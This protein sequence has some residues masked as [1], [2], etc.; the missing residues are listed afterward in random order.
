MLGLA[1]AAF[2][3]CAATEFASPGGPEPAGV[4]TVMGRLRQDPYD[5]E[6]LISFG[7]SKGGSAGHLALALREPGEPD[8]WV[9]SANFYADRAA[10]HAT[11]FYTDEL[12]VRVPKNEYLYGT[13]SSL[14]PAAQ[15]GLDYGEVYKRT[16]VGVR[17][18]GVPRAER[19]ALAAFFARINAD[20]R[21]RAA[22]TAYHQG[23]VV[24]DYM[25]FNCAKSIGAAFR[26]GAG[27][28][29]LEVKEPKVLP[30]V[31]R[32]VRATQAN[33][34]SDMALK[35]M[36]E[37]HA[38]GRTM[39]VVLYKKYPGSGWI[40]PLEGEPKVA[41]RELPNRFPSM[42]SLDFAN[43]QGAYEDYDNL[44]AMYLLYN[45]GKYSVVV[46]PQTW[47]LEIE[48]SKTPMPYARAEYFAKSAARADSRGF[49]RR[50]P[51]IPKGL[52]IGDPVDYSHLYEFDRPAARPAS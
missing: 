24:Y 14:G 52:R 20:Y 38:R 32:A 6:L 25:R 42:L 51:F 1:L 44:H 19:E 16:V 41:F 27:Y 18:Q 10:K 17:V 34:P 9:Y 28:E 49:L 40:D 33:L 21:A 36:R 43:D 50:L 46:N 3:D 5:L 15:F 45:L 23:E 11:G 29:R 26:H 37:W 12:M 13:R 8:D 31:T 47:M 7:T 2:P 39:D 48:R 22:N 4:D 35:L 30:G